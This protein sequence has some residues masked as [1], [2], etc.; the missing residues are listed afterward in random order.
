MELKHFRG[1]AGSGRR[2]HE[3]ALPA[4]VTRGRL[5]SAL[6]AGFVLSMK[7]KERM[8][9]NVRGGTEDCSRMQGHFRMK[10]FR[11]DQLGEGGSRVETCVIGAVWL[12]GCLILLYEHVDEI[13]LILQ[14][15]TQ[16]PRL[17]SGAR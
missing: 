4:T 1:W 12:G 3:P 6:Q 8:E 15:T 16:P 14:G 11:A 9:M 7:P 5:L 2:A 17:L 13:M 10:K